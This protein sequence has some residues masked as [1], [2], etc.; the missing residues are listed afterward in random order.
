MPRNTLVLLMTAT[1]GFGCTQ[2]TGETPASE[3]DTTGEIQAAGS[4]A[5]PTESGIVDAERA[6]VAARSELPQPKTETDLLD[7]SAMDGV[8]VYCGY[9]N[10]EDLVLVPGGGLL[11]VSEMGEFMLDTP[12]RLSTLDLATGARGAIDIDW[13]AAG[14]AWGEADCEAPDVAAFSPHGID[15]GTRSDGSHQLLVVNHGLRE[16]VEFFEL[17]DGDDGWSLA[18]RGCALPPGDPFINDVAGLADGGFF[19]THMWDKSTS[20]EEVV[21]QYQAGE[22]IGWVWEWHPDEGFTKLAGSDELM[23]NGIA[24]SPDERK[25]FVNVYLGNRTIRI[26]RETGTVD[27]AF[28][29]QQPDNITVDADGALWV[30]SHKHDPLGQTCAAVAEGPCLLPYELVR[31]DADT[32]ETEV[33]FSGDGPP[34]GYSTVALRVGD[35]LY[36]GSAHGDRIASR[37]LT[38]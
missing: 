27:G 4:T 10:P 31:A 15:L 35:R 20:F 23:P 26:D 21:A 1:L 18:W 29:V 11:V 17:L 33:V 8:S 22:D 7:C 13:S 2:E 5:V 12:G 3:A 30:A 9:Q 25:V 28:D 36:F 19:V 6:A 24:V 32:L 34:M 16:A 38:D 14:A 37:A